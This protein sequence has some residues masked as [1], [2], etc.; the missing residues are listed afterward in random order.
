MIT[1]LEVEADSPQSAREMAIS[2][3]NAMGYTRIEA[4]FTTPLGDRRY[5]VQMTVTR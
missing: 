3:A 4:V 1:T 2:Q 5:K